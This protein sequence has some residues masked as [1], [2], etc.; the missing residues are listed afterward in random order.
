VHLFTEK[1]ADEIDGVEKSN[2]GH[3]SKEEKLSKQKVE[4]KDGEN[5]SHIT[6]DEIYMDSFDENLC[7]LKKMKKNA[8]CC[9]C[10]LL[11]YNKQSYY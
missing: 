2:K 1:A 6:D 10:C 7:L 4:E 3:N 11:N 8:Y 9:Y 5:T